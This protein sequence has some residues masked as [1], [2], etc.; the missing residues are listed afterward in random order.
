LGRITGEVTNEDILGSIFSRFC[1]GK[2]VSTIESVYPLSV[3]GFQFFP[4][5]TPW[6]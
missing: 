4:I 5:I 3:I 2:W 6:L 1:I